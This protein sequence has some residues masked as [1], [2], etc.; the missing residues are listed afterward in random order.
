MDKRGSFF[1]DHLPEILLALF[2]LAII[3]I[4][5]FVLKGK[6]ISVIDNFGNF[7]RGR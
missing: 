7:F 4:A 5:I 3:A 6:G 2:V 1:S